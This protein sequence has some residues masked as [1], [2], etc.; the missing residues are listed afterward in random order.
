MPVCFWRRE[1]GAEAHD[2]NGKASRKRAAAGWW[3][4]GMAGGVEGTAS[5]VSLFSYSFLA[6]LSSGIILFAS[7]TSF[8]KGAPPFSDDG[9]GPL[10]P[11]PDDRPTDEPRLILLLDPAPLA[12]SANPKLGCHD[13]YTSR[14]G[15]RG[16]GS[17]RGGWSE[18]GGGDKRGRGYKDAVCSR[19]SCFGVSPSVA[20]ISTAP[21]LTWTTKYTDFPPFVVSAAIH[22]TKSD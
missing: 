9:G 13:H 12:A 18:G 14:R 2:Y 11:S 21:Q 22:T 7:G 1:D 19:T 20:P 17:R 5:Q 8:I 10:G 6:L 4:G 16:E 15:G 3:R